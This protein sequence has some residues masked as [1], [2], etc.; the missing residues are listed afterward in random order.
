MTYKKECLIM[1][2][3]DSKITKLF[4]FIFKLFLLH[5]F[6]YL[7]SVGC[8][9]VCACAHARW[10]TYE[11]MYR[12]PMTYI[13]RSQDNLWESIFFI[14]YVGLVNQTQAIKLRGNH[15]YLLSLLVSLIKLLTP[16][17]LNWV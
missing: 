14:Y 2:T 9:F 16:M 5:L 12:H 15:L 10:H 1:S 11:C 8:V 13:W 4:Y 7:F 3:I 17:I 6:I